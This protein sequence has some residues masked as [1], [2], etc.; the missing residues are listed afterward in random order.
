ME[1]VT[2]IRLDLAKSIIQVH[3]ASVDGSVLFRRKVSSKKLLAFLSE[4]DPFIVAMEACAGSHHWGREIA[5]LG[6]RMKLIAPLYVKPFV[7]LWRGEHNLTNHEV[8]V[9]R[10]SAA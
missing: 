9:M 6:H 5:K 1:K 2:I 8:V 7:K 4:L 10:R 3:A